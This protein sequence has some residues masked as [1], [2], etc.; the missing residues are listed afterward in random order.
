MSLRTTLQ[1]AAGIAFDVANSLG[2]VTPCNYVN[3]TDASYDPDAGTIT[4][5]ST[6]VAINPVLTDPTEREMQ[7]GNF[8]PG[9][10]VA[11]VEASELVGLVPTL[12]DKIVE[13]ATSNAWNVWQVKYDPAQIVYRLFIRSAAD[14]R[15][16]PA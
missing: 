1:A 13:T 7:G 12:N 3:V 16:I 11:V 15:T 6:T 5:T 8:R 10:K 14:S 9:D 4:P 2:A